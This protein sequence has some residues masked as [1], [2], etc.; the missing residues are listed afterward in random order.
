MWR[1]VGLRACCKASLRRRRPDMHVAYS[2]QELVEAHV[3]PAPSVGLTGG[4]LNPGTALV[5]Y[6]RACGRRRRWCPPS[7]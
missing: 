2:E 1:S 5:A 7:L 4:T 6:G 3:E